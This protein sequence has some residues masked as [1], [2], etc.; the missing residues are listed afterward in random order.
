MIAT[1]TV[2]EL[3]PA[4]TSAAGPARVEDGGEC[5][6]AFADSPLGAL[7]LIATGKGLVRVVYAAEDHPAVLEAMSATLGR[8]ARRRPTGPI[9]TARR[10][11]DEYFAGVR[12]T[13]S[14]P[15]DLSLSSPFRRTVQRNLHLVE[16][17]HTAS[18]AQMARLVDSPQAVRA[19]G[20]ACATNPLPILLPCHRLRRV[21]GGPGGYLR[22]LEAKAALVA[23]E[24]L[25]PAA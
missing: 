1:S 2:P 16:Y 23:L 17:G 22:G 13:F 12:R 19:V 14:T 4:R 20:S 15:V 8:S 11:L 6:Y 21:D 18:Y 9:D 3:G 7:L 5:A 10:Q 25:Q 24:A